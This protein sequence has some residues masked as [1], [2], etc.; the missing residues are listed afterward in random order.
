MRPQ[1]LYDKK[2]IQK[3]RAK[4]FPSHKPLHSLLL[5]SCTSFNSEL[6]RFCG[7]KVAPAPRFLPVCQF[8]NQIHCCF[9]GTREERQ[10]KGLWPGPR[11]N[12]AFFFVFHNFCAVVF[13]LIFFLQDKRNKTSQELRLLSNVTLNCQ[14]AKIVINSGSQLSEL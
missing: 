3:F 14:V 10:Q 6:C 8:L 13:Y 2:N 5:C 9:N 1:I 4:T 11:P 7:I 12:I